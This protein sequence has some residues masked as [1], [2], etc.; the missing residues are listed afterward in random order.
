MRKMKTFL[1]VI[2]RS[3]GPIKIGISSTPEKRLSSVQNGCP[4]KIEVLY[5]RKFYTR[6]DARYIEQHFHRTHAHVRLKGEWFDVSANSIIQTIECSFADSDC[7]WR[8][9]IDGDEL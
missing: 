7:K 2:G 9:F 8:E 6:D 5:R 4:F 3:E 1:Y